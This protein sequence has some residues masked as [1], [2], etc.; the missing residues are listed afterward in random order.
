MTCDEFVNLQ[1]H[2]DKAT[3]A[4]K[5]QVLAG[6]AYT[7]HADQTVQHHQYQSVRLLTLAG[8]T[9][10][11]RVTARQGL[12]RVP[13]CTAGLLAVSHCTRRAVGLS[14][15]RAVDHAVLVRLRLYLPDLPAYADIFVW[16][17]AVGKRLVLR[18]A[19]CNRESAWRKLMKTAPPVVW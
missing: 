13:Y 5:V 1:E 7:V 10:S 11:R 4:V 9:V 14:G 6:P 15:C 8:V 2:V 16:L 3:A 17:G 18:S 12:I 19:Q